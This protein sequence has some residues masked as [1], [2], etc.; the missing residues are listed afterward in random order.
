MEGTSNRLFIE[1]L[2]HFTWWLLVASSTFAVYMLTERRRI[3]RFFGIHKNSR[4]IRI[5]VSRVHVRR[6]G[7]PTLEEG[8]EGFDGVV[9]SHIE[10][11]AALL[12]QRKLQ[13]IFLLKLPQGFRSWLH[14]VNPN[15]SPIVAEI[16]PSPELRPQ[17][18][19]PDGNLVILGGNNYNALTKRCLEIFGPQP[20]TFEFR[21]D[22]QQHQL[23]IYNHEIE[24]CYPARLP[25]K[26]LGII[27]RMRSKQGCTIFICAGA[28]QGATFGSVK[29]LL[30]NW[31][32]LY[33]KYRNNNF[34]ICVS[35]PKLAGNPES[36]DVGAAIKIY[37]TP[38][39]S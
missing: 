16:E 28:G 5:F 20:C 38:S 34:G 8:H 2:G 33:R 9:I 17:D 21:Y 37:D 10:Y 3:R 32:D 36:E 11:K 18:E 14:D 30:D 1:V 15:L 6:G 26:E 12:L 27:Q 31:S 19:P 22:Q 39:K 35:F 24:E 13:S 7:A 4:H 23:T 25:T 29:Y